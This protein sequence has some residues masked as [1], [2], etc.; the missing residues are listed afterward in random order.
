M[1][2]VFCPPKTV[3]AALEYQQL[4]AVN[5]EERAFAFI[6]E[7]AQQHQFHASADLNHDLVDVGDGLELHPPDG[8]QGIAGVPVLS[9][10]AATG[11]AVAGAKILWEAAKFLTPK[12]IR[13]FKEHHDKAHKPP[14]PT[15][16]WKRFELTVMKVSQYVVPMVVGGLIIW[17]LAD[18]GGQAK[19]IIAGGG[20]V[21]QFMST[22]RGNSLAKD[23]NEVIN[24]Y[25]ADQGLAYGIA[26]ANPTLAS[27]AAVSLPEAEEE[28]H[29]SLVAGADAPPERRWY[30]CFTDPC[31]C[32]TACRNFFRR[33]NAG[34]DEAEPDLEA[35]LPNN[36]V[37]PVEG[38]DDDHSGDHGVV[39]MDHEDDLEA[40][41]R[42][43]NLEDG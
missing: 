24:Q 14:P 30:H 9:S 23:I 43:S 42:D 39:R 22:K 36:L 37:N 19:L 32:F 13:W 34:G 35:G 21:L 26:A 11:A 41:R 4:F 16:K 12:A 8:A 2:K 17:Q 15:F 27:L 5:T 3:Q 29:R 10:A 38:V 6:A 1:T 33:N 20:V 25:A 18:P 40:V 7:H 28:D 31:G